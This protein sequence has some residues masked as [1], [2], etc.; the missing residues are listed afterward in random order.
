M[1]IYRFQGFQ[2]AQSAGGA[3]QCFIQVWFETRPHTNACRLIRKNNN[4]QKPFGLFLGL[5]QIVQADYHLEDLN[6]QV[7]S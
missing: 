3:A 6:L 4:K 7:M 5:F 2:A 1:Y